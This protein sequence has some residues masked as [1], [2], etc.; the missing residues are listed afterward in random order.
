MV[1]KRS[2]LSL[3][4]VGMPFCAD[5]R[6]PS[7]SVSSPGQP[8]LDKRRGTTP[9]AINTSRKAI[10]SQSYIGMDAVLYC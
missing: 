7:R 4:S 1:G 10:P 6:L 2:P 5:D 9:G 3:T 8:A